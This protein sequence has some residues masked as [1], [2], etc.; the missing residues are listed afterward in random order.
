ML[1]ID[2]H[3]HPLLIMK[4]IL[5]L[6]SLSFGLSI[7]QGAVM[8]ENRTDVRTLTDFNLSLVASSDTVLVAMIESRNSGNLTTSIDINSVAM[9]PLDSLT[10]TY[11]SVQAFAISL[12][13]VSVGD[14]SVD[15]TGNEGSGTILQF[16]QL[17]GAD[18]DVSNIVSSTVGQATS[19]VNVVD[20]PFLGLGTADAG[21]ML[22]VGGSIAKVK[23]PFGIS[24]G[25][26]DGT[27]SISYTAGDLHQQ[28][29]SYRGQS[30]HASVSGLLSPTASYQTT[31]GAQSGGAAIAV[32]VAP[33]PEPGTFVLVGLSGI[34]VVITVRRR[35]G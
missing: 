27:G 28:G 9:T 8:F 13:T 17:S 18:Q 12:G 2:S 15:F 21:S 24:F 33:V 5:P 14:V 4:I 16:Y 19:N 35:R 23:T 29:S 32:L 6:L 1:E 20:D 7:A 30:A 31:D 10:Q 34:A 3:S 26:T 11:G 25:G 22:L